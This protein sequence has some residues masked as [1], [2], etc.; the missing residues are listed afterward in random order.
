[1]KDYKMFRKNNKKKPLNQFNKYSKYSKFFYSPHLNNS[2][3]KEKI[4]KRKVNYFNYFFLDLMS[5]VFKTITNSIT[6]LHP[7][8]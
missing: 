1:M 6:F 3:L 2:V 8:I 7:I 4:S 5:R